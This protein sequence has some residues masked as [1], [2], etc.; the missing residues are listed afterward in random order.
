MKTQQKKLQNPTNNCYR[1]P[2]VHKLEQTQLDI[3]RMVVPTT[4]KG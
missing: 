4:Q 1:N 3:L 2:V